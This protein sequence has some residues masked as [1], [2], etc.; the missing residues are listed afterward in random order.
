MLKKKLGGDKVNELQ[1]TRSVPATPAFLP[2]HEAEDAEAEEYVEPER[3]FDDQKR[4]INERIVN[5][6]KGMTTVSEMRKTE[7]IYPEKT[8]IRADETKEVLNLDVV[9]KQML[10]K[11]LDRNN[12]NRKKAAEDQ[13]PSTVSSAGS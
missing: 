10:M 4:Y 13:S 1:P 8:D 6:H 11:A 7:D 3:V 12:G 2:R 9:E 5:E